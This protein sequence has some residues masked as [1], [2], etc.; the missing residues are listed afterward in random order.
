M[1]NGRHRGK[2]I[3]S[4]TSIWKMH[5]QR[6]S[7]TI[8]QAEFFDAECGMS[9]STGTCNTMGTASTMACM[10]EVRLKN[11]VCSACC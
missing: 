2:V 4:G 6:K 11:E 7:G 1:L 8:S 3:G 9:R 10:V 5:A